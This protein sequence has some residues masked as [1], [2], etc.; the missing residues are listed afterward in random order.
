MTT[1]ILKNPKKEIAMHRNRTRVLYITG[2]RLNHSPL[3]IF[4]EFQY[5]LFGHE[6]FCLFL[7]YSSDSF[8][9]YFCQL[10]AKVAVQH[11]LPV[12]VDSRG[13]VPDVADEAEAEMTAATIARAIALLVES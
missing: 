1:F 2:F 5:L 9:Y 7:Y 13:V 11:R 8:L 10:K 12:K 3:L 6:D 4:S